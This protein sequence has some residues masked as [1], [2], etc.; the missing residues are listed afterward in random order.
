[1]QSYYPFLNNNKNF[2]CNT[3]H[4][5]KHKRL[6]FSSSTSHAS[7][8]FELLHIDIW[9]PC[10]KTSMHGHRYFVTI[11]DDFSRYTWTH[12][13]HTKSETRRIITDFVAY[14]ETQFDSKVKILRSDN[15]A[16]FL[17]NDFYARK[18]IIHQTTC[19]ETP[20]Q[21]G[22]AERKHQH[23]LNVTQALLYQAQLPLNFWCFALL[24]AAYLI[25]RIP[26]PFL[27]NVSPYEKLYAQPC[28]ISN[29][30]VFGC[31]CYISTLQNH[32][33]K[34]DPRAHPCIFLG[35]KPHTKG[36]L[37]YNLHSHNITASR[38]IVFYEDHFPI[39]HETQHSNNT[40]THISS[41]PFSSN[42]QIPDTTITHTTNPNNPTYLMIPSINSPPS[43]TQD[44]SPS[45]TSSDTQLTSFYENETSTH[46]LT[47]L[48]SRSHFTC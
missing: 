35:F 36:Y 43:S 29:I 8:K 11:I 23:L 16:E 9:G 19:V 22:I 18:G 6:P 39:L 17:M 20:E 48:S 5:A 12:L 10:S 25:N 37:V 1:M 44:N 42:T 26:T 7:N 13:M 14:V 32:R 45:P 38:N 3:C 46:I 34:L 28:D 2:I 33:Q 41:I 47:G 31:L 30:R 40:H 15:E 27:K 24:H 4:Y 21:N